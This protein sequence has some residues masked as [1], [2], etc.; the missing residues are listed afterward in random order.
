VCHV[1]RAVRNRAAG[2]FAAG[3]GIFENQL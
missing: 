2:C 3:G 1:T